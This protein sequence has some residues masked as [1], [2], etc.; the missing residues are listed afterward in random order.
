MDDWL[1][2]WTDKWKIL[3]ISVTYTY[4]TKTTMDGHTNREQTITRF[5]ST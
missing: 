1:N 3:Y 4:K 5:L 2:E